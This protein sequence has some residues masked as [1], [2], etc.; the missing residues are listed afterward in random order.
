MKYLAT[1]LAL[2]A[3]AHGRD[4]PHVHPHGSDVLIAALL[5]LMV[6]YFIRSVK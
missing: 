6:A 1:V 2:P 5:L 3:F 4:L